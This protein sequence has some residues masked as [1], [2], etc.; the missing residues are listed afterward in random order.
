MVAKLYMEISEYK[1][2][3][4]QKDFKVFRGFYGGKQ[5]RLK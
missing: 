2:V 1:K 3:Q 5:V 4:I